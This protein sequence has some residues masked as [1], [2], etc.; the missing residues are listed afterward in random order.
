[1]SYAVAARIF[2]WEVGWFGGPR[3]RHFKLVKCEIAALGLGV[4]IELSI[5]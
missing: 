2:I 4:N 3:D 5:L 1:M